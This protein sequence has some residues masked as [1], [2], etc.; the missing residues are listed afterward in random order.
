MVNA[1]VSVIR[2]KIEEISRDFLEAQ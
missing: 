1:D 2:N